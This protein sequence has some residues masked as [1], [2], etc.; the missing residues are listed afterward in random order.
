MQL[1]EYYTTYPRGE[2]GLELDMCLRYRKIREEIS[3]TVADGTL[4][5]VGCGKGALG[6]YATEAS[7]IEYVGIDF[8]PSAVKYA[9]KNKK[10][11]SH[12]I[13]ADAHH[14]P[15]KSEAFKTI[16]CSEVLEH[17]PDYWQI[18]EQFSAVLKPQGTVLIT[19]PNR[20]NFNV[21]LSLAIS[22]KGIGGQQYDKP[23]KPKQL[24]S[25]LRANGFQITKQ[26][27]FCTYISISSIIHTRWRKASEYLEQTLQS[28]LRHMPFYPFQLYFFVQ[29]RKTSNDKSSD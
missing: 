10:K 4:L 12:Y 25:N 3:A 19:V 17:V 14:L 13:V 16:L 6:K 28:I 20:Y 9:N 11:T 2:G 18:T 15:F 26:Q 24:I 21:A 5:E 29:A 23:P 1:K 7:R 27:N 22:G 8:S